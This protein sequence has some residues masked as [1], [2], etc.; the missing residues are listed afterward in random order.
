MSVGGELV[1]IGFAEWIIARERRRAEATLEL[2]SFLRGEREG[3][4]AP[5]GDEMGSPR[6][7]F[8]TSDDA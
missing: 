7:A 1:P 8:P 6:T 2:L 4:R 3:T 5:D